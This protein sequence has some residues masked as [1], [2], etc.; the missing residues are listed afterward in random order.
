MAADSARRDG[1]FVVD[2]LQAV[3]SA[4]VLLEVRDRRLGLVD[5]VLGDL[6]SVGGRPH[7]ETRVR[8]I[9]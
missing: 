8:A 3:P 5:D 1:S 7:L 9:S 6:L 2:V 4:E